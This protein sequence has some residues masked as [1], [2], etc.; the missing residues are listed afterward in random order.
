MLA[1]KVYPT[2]QAEAQELLALNWFL[3]EVKDPQLTFGVRHKSPTKLDEAVAATLKLETYLPKMSVAVAGVVNA[4]DSGIAAV[5][6]KQ[7]SLES[8]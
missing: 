4:L 2:L 6:P 7:V 8:S 1:E 3:S 5:T